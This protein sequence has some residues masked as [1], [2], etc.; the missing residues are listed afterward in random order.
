MK[1]SMKIGILLLVVAAVAGCPTQLPIQAVILSDDNGSN[2]API[3]LAEIDT[4]VNAANLTYDGSNFH[5][6]FDHADVAY[7]KASFLNAVPYVPAGWQ[8]NPALGLYFNEQQLY[9]I[10][11]NGIGAKYPDKI[12]VLFRFN[13]GGGW[14][15]GPPSLRYVSMPSYTHT[16][17]GKPPPGGPN[18]TLLAHEL[19]HYL[20]L[21]HTFTGVACNTATLSNTDGDY[22]GQDGV[23]SQDDILD[24]NPDPNADCAP[25]TGLNCP[26]VTVVV[27]G[28][29]FDPPWTNI[30]T[31]HDCLPETISLNQHQVINYT[32]QKPMRASIPK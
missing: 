15:W 20:G 1:T 2:L 26:A 14:S 32:L 18:D 23:T 5:F 12:V 4:W 11:A 25:T 24:T 10:I 9:D 30:M 7:V 29:T 22:Y 16:G 3:T 19:G 27:N 21:P 17:I 8:P 31:Y 6:T 28:Y 13:G